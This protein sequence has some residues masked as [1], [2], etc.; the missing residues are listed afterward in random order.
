[1][2][3]IDVA[4]VTLTTADVVTSSFVFRM[5]PLLDSDSVIRSC[6]RLTTFKSLFYDETITKSSLC[7]F[8]CF[9]T[10]ATHLEATSDL[11]TEKF[12]GASLRFVASLSHQGLSWHF[13]PPGAPHIGSL[14]DA[15]S[16]VSRHTSTGRWVILNIPFKSYP[17][18]CVVSRH[19]S[20]PDQFPMSGDP[21][22][23]LTSGVFSDRRTFTRP[24]R[25]SHHRR[26]PFYPEPVAAT[27]RP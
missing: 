6:G 8:V 18:Y 20:T 15:G 3:S 16:R 22:D 10:R 2:F 9:C 11:T 25:I 4:L 24:R 12:L 1:M 23:I 14:W 5:L 19:V 26:S 21:S 27:Q 17:L 13:N 7:D